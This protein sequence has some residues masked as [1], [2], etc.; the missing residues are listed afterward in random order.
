MSSSSPTLFFEEQSLLVV[1]NNSDPLLHG[2]SAMHAEVTTRHDCMFLE[3]TSQISTV[4]REISEKEELQR[5]EERKAKRSQQKNDS[6]R[7][8]K[9]KEHAK[10]T[11]ARLNSSPEKK[12]EINAKRKQAR[13]NA[14]EL[15]SPEEQIEIN[16]KRRQARQHKKNKVLPTMTSTYT[17]LQ[18][19]S[20]SSSFMNTRTQ[21]EHGDVHVS[22]ISELNDNADD[23]EDVG[24][25]IET[26]F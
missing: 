20:S 9:I 6:T 14:K 12:I 5:K 2:Q 8:N 7:K 26:V 16:A 1:P 17:D 15:R 24:K 18:E 10:R 3:S 25:D 11:Q 22:G 19:S 23:I 13:L 4:E 21:S